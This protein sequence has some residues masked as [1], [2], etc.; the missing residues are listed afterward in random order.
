M[1]SNLVEESYAQSNK[2]IKEFIIVNDKPGKNEINLVEAYKRSTNTLGSYVTL[3]WKHK[4]EITLISRKIRNYSLDRTQR[5]PLNF[6]MTAEPGSGKSHFVKCLANKLS[7]LNVRAVTYNMSAFEKP[8]DF[9]HSLEIVRNL[10]VKDI[11]PILFIDEFDSDEKNYSFLLPLLW[12]GEM[13]LSNRNLNLGKIVIILA[14]SKDE[15]SK[16]IANTK[17]MEEETKEN[18]NSTKLKDLLSRIN[19]GDFEIPKLDAVKGSRDRRVDKVCLTIALL[20]QR[21]GQDL[22]LVPWALLKFI[23]NTKFRYGVRSIAQLIDLIPFS[24]DCKNKITVDNL[25]LPLKSLAAL[26]GSSLPYHLLTS[27]A[28]EIIERWNNA[29]IHKTLVRFVKDEFEEDPI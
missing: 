24:E 16:T 23:S 10:K 2:E 15:I 14:G 20:Q 19:G 29:I 21:F 12:D 8:E 27:D 13:Q 17:K 1:E 5:R 9:I 28:E 25:K 6:L 7:N 18:S 26:N 3:D 4:L 22:Q 11:L